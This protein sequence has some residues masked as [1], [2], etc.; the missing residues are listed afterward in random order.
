M[1]LIE[2]TQDE[3]GQRL[4]R[5]LRRRFPAL[6]QG[7][8]EKLLRKGIIRVNAEKVKSSF[9]LE[10]GHTV[11]LPHIDVPPDAP[12]PPA[13]KV[14]PQDRAM[15]SAAILH[16]DADILI[17]NKP[18]GLAVQ[19]GSKQKRH[20]DALL[21]EFGSPKLVHRLDKDTSGVLVLAKS[22]AAARQLTAQFRT[23]DV[24]K[25]YWAAVAGVP[26]HRVGT[27]RYAL[28]KAGGKN[29]KMVC[30]ENVRD[31]P[32]AKPARTEYRVIET[33]AKRCAWVVLHP[34]TGRTHQLRAHMAQLG[35]PIIGD[36]KYGTN[37][38]TNEGAGWGAQL[39]GA[40]S[41]KLHL[42][43]RTIQFAH[44]RTG[45]TLSV[46]APPPPHMQKTWDLFGWK[47]EEANA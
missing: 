17:L 7:M 40:I 37:A 5:W 42:H 33:A 27:I 46:T 31:H 26:P 47:E 29:E 32:E 19:G 23:R 36:G 39:G 2:I 1:K 6:K 34:I 45:S 4:D 22:D 15:I 41:R 38:Q 18:A 25:T 12:N 3:A 35:H 24:Q 13:R 43:A 8:I 30:F 28:A 21:A 10:A 14:S 9:Q 44:P 20:L 11:K 16:E